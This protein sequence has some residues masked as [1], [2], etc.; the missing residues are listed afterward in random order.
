MGYE[1]NPY[2]EIAVPDILVNGKVNGTTHRPR[3]SVPD[4]DYFEPKK[5]V[6]FILEIDGKVYGAMFCHEKIWW[7]NSEIFIDEMFVQ[8]EFRHK[9]YI[10]CC[11]Q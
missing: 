9:L 8:P 7:N 10:A 3:M 2:V 6:G 1:H 4:C 11:F 5:F